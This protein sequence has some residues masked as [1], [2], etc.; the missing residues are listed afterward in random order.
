M[1]RLRSGTLPK[2]EYVKTQIQDELVYQ[3]FLADHNLPNSNDFKKLLL[4]D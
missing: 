2:T 1:H 3:Q 4:D